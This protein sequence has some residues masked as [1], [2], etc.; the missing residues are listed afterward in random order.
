MRECYALTLTHSH[1]HTNLRS[2]QENQSLSQRINEVVSL[3]FI[4]SKA[5]EFGFSVASL[6][7]NPILVACGHIYCSMRTHIV[8]CGR[9]FSV[10]SLVLNPIILSLS[11]LLNLI[12][13]ALSLLLNLI[14]PRLSL[15]SMI[16]LGYVLLTLSLSFRLL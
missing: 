10:A 5:L 4:F 8:A 14:F 7:L 3:R 6:V 11:L 2:P 1:S 12:C 15:C 16:N 9:G 13:H